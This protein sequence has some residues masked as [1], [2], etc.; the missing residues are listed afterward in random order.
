MDTRIKQ[1]KIAAR[2]CIDEYPDDINH[3]NAFV[4]GVIW[5]DKHPAKKPGMWNLIKALFREFI[6]D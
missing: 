5:A 1:A 2:K 6:H 3:Y 4:L